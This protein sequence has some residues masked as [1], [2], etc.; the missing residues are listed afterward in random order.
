MSNRFILAKSLNV[1]DELVWFIR[2]D[3]ILF[4]CFWK[5]SNSK[6]LT[7]FLIKMD[8]SHDDL[9]MPYCREGS[10]QVMFTIKY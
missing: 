1:N 2:R 8:E 7:F 4:K 9:A 10:I 6:E 3:N 5:K